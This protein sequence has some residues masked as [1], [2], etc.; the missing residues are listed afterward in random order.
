MKQVQ[1]GY[2]HYIYIHYPVIPLQCGWPKGLGIYCLK[3]LRL[4]FH[5]L[6]CRFSLSFPAPRP[7]TKFFLQ[8]LAN[9]IHGKFI[10][11]E[12][13]KKRKMPAVFFK[14]KTIFMRRGKFNSQ[15]QFLEFLPTIFY[16]VFPFRTLRKTD[17]L[18]TRM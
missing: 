13:I 12:Q 8:P 6:S 14:R 7:L 17:D 10:S 18:Y 15:N 2:P 1:W 16:Y 11:T 4:T 3:T 9:S 5:F